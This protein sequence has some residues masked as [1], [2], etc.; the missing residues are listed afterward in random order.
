MTQNHTQSNGHE[1]GLRPFLDFWSDWIEQ[2]QEQTRVLLDSVKEGCDLAGMRHLWLES[3][4]KSLEAHMRT[5]AFLEAM[6][7]H[8]DV[9]SP[10]RP[11]DA[12]A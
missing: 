12:P 5:S 8:F 3:L 1:A 10:E 4:G 2:S 11:S 6:R 7:R 9:M